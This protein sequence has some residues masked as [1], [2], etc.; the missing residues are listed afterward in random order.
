MFLVSSFDA[1]SMLC[2]PV[3][4][5]ASSHQLNQ[6]LEVSQSSQ[7]VDQAFVLVFLCS[8]IATKTRA[9]SVIS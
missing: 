5:D 1:E 6:V 2:R 3:L 8:D 7:P 9:E 4:L